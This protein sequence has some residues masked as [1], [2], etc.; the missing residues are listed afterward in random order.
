MINYVDISSVVLV[1]KIFNVL[2]AKYKEKRL[3]VVQVN[4]VEAYE[5]LLG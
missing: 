2:Q 1:Q 5:Q 4:Y 3:H